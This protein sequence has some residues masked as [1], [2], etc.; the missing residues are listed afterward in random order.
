MT[1]D[2]LISIIMPICAGIAAAITYRI[3][4]NDAKKEMTHDKE[5]SK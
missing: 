5:E 2:T 1:T 4:Y 3:G